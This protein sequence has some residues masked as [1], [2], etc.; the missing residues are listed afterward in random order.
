MDDDQLRHSIDELIETNER[1]IK[2]L[3]LWRHFVGG[4]ISGAGAT[5]GAIIAIA[6][7]VWILNRLAVFD[8]LRPAV[9][10]VLPYVDRSADLPQPQYDSE[11]LASPS[12]ETSPSP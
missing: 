11:L 1:L 5:I 12:P 6:I 4:L 9:E 3:T 8:L 2:R 10:N 7:L